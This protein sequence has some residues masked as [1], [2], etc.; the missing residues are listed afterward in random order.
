[1]SRV[2]DLPVIR[3][4]LAELDRIATE[5]P[6]I[7]QGIGKWD[8]A[9]VERIVTRGKPRKPG[10]ERQAEYRRQQAAKGIKR[11]IF[12]AT[13]EARLA[14]A[15]LRVMYPGKSRDTILC[16]ALINL[17]ATQ[18]DSTPSGTYSPPAPY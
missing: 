3:K 15:K 10:N 6:E 11:E 5:H 1:M 16:D 9:A 8:E 7:C 13:P 14:W 4:A 12:F 18:Q 17:L 2:M